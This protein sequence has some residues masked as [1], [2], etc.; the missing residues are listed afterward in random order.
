MP[1]II[2]LRSNSSSGQPLVSRC[3]TVWYN[4]T[5]EQQKTVMDYTWVLIQPDKSK[6]EKAKSGLVHLPIAPNRKHDKSVQ[7]FY[8]LSIDRP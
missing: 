3:D 7:H 8:V 6:D 5:P 1:S 4:L 2:L